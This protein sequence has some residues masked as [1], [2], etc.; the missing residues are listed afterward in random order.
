MPDAAQ[1]ERLRRCRL[2]SGRIREESDKTEDAGD[3]PSAG[4]N[5]ADRC[6][7]ISPARASN[8]A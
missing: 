5:A 6:S 4:L 8:A 7:I 1:R 3:G 2:E